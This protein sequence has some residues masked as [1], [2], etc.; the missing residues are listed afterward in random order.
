[1]LTAS[2]VVGFDAVAP[3]FQSEQTMDGRA[4]FSLF[5]LLI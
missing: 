1:L 5:R 3:T 4:K 2:W